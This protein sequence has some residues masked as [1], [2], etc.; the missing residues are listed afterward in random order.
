MIAQTSE[1]LKAKKIE[2]AEAKRKIDAA[3]KAKANAWRW[4]VSCP[5]PSGFIKAGNMVMVGLSDE[6]RVFNASTGKL[7]WSTKV[8]GVVYGLAVA[9][10]RLFVSTGLGH[11]YA[12]AP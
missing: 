10:G 3:K 2:A 5:N 7:A 8:D 12:F 1:L 4:S 11:I 6:V 9:N